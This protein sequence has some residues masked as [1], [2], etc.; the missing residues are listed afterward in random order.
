MFQVSKAIDPEAL[1]YYELINTNLNKQLDSAIEWLDS[2]EAK[3][4]FQNKV[5]D[6][7]KAFKGLDEVIRETVRADADDFNEMIEN[8]YKIGSKYGYELLDKEIEVFESDRV[9]LKNVQD[10]NYTKLKG[11]SSD[12]CSS[13]KD[14]LWSGIIKQQGPDEIATQ[15]KKVL[16]NTTPLRNFTPRQRADMIARTELSRAKNTASLQAFANYGV[17]EIEIVTAGDDD[18]CS[19]CIANEANNPHPISL[20][21]Y[22]CPQHPH[23]RC[24]VVPVTETM[25]GVKEDNH[26][27]IDMVPWS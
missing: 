27:I 25:S 26:L 7:R 15:I 21:R 3:K 12:V 20:V 22:M 16:D 19:S 13:I 23:C 24:T 17:T 1:E 11:L 8:F 5:Y 2:D 4:F 14:E 6:R 18:V 9:A 10:Y